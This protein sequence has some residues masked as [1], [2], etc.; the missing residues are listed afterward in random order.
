MSQ[1]PTGIVTLPAY[2][3]DQKAKNQRARQLL[4]DLTPLPVNDERKKWHVGALKLDPVPMFEIV[5][6]ENYRPGPFDL[7]IQFKRPR[8]CI[9]CGALEGAIEHD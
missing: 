6:P 5:D 8:R 2:Q 4:E 9:C 7:V 3:A 1:F